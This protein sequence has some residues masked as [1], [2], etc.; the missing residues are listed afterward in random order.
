MTKHGGSVWVIK[1][2]RVITKSDGVCMGTCVRV[3]LI[4]KERLSLGT[5]EPSYEHLIQVENVIK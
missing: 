1:S 4:E 2:E 3:C 5:G